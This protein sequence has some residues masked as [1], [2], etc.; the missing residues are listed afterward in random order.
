MPLTPVEERLFAGL[1]A[2][3]GLVLRGARL[4]AELEL[5]PAEL[6]ARADELRRLPRAA[7][8]RPGRRAPAP[9]ARHPRRRPAAPGRA[10][11]EPAARRHPGRPLPGARRRAA[12]RPG[13]RRRRGGGDA[14]PALA[15]HLP[16]AARGGGR[17]ARRCARRSPAPAARSRSSRRRSGGTRSTSRRRRTSAAWRRSRTPPSTPAAATVRV[18]LRGE[19]DAWTLTVADDGVGL[20]PGA[21]SRRAPGWPTCATGS[22]PSAERCRPRLGA[23][24]AAPGSVPSLPAVHS[25]RPWTAVAD[26]RARIA[27]VAGRRHRRPGASPTSWSRPRPWRSRPR[28][29]WPCTASRSSTARSLGSLRDGRADHLAL[30]PAPDRLAAQRSSGI[31]SAVSLAGRG[32]RLLGAGGGRTRHATSLGGVAAWVSALIGGQLAI[33]GARADVPAGPGRPARSRG[34]G[35]TPRGR[36]V[37][38]A[39]LCLL[40]ILSHRP[41]HVPAADAE[42]TTSGRSGGSC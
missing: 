12:G 17:R 25:L 31:V 24:R 27:W 2:Q 36:P 5:R 38:G 21:P 26:V 20:R 16:A 34:A 28:P 32:L 35:G 29:R 30:R 37:L 23:R 8:R 19:P 22:S 11:G 10:G 4:R 18:E 9:G 13:G 33:A 42:E 40:A 7:G 1:A 15:R 14:G 41:D 39:A 6:S 3:A